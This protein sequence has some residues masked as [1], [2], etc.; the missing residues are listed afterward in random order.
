MKVKLE[1]QTKKTIKIILAISLVL[2]ILAVS[3]HIHEIGVIQ[4]YPNLLRTYQAKAIDDCTICLLSRS[5]IHSS[6]FVK[7]FQFEFQFEFILILP[8]FLLISI[9]LRR[10]FTPRAPPLI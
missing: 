8:F 9:C 2:S 10:Y 7:E 5:V 3:F 1:I 4:N 6:L